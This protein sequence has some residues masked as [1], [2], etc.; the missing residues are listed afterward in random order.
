MSET[1]ERLK[2]QMAIAQMTTRK[3]GAKKALKAISANTG[4]LNMELLVLSGVL[5][6]VK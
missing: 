1:I 4:E 5:R 3:Y 2:T 6:R